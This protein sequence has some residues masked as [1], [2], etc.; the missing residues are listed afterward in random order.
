MPNHLNEKLMG[1]S[2][3]NQP[4]LDVHLIPKD[5]LETAAHRAIQNLLVAAFPQYTEIFSQVSYWRLAH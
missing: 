3:P 5:Q 2:L 4:P 1:L